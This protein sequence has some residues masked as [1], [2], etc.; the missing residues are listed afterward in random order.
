MIEAGTDEAIVEITVRCP[1]CQRN[2]THEI[3]RT[4]WRRFVQLDSKNYLLGL[5]FGCTRC[6]ES[7]EVSMGITL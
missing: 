1:H 4:D 3:E 2:Q 7:I 6:D 5:R